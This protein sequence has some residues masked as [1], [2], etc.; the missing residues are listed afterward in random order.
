MKH[1]ALRLVVDT[2]I[3]YYGWSYNKILNCL[4]I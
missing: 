4:K 1:S 3:H 2:G